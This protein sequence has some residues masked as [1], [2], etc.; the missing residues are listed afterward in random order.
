MKFKKRQQYKLVKHL[1]NTPKFWS[2]DEQ[3]SKLYM[4]FESK[5]CYYL[6]MERA[7]I[8]SN[9]GSYRTGLKGDGTEYIL[10]NSSHKKLAWAS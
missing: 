5:G 1:G 10:W 4:L 3:N 6:L 2:Y 8:S 7:L 9:F